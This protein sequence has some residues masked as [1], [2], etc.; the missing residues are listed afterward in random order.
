[1]KVVVIGR[2][3][4]DSRRRIAACFPEVPEMEAV[5]NS[6]TL[7][8]PFREKQ[9]SPSLRPVGWTGKRLGLSGSGAYSVLAS[10]AS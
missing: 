9:K 2:F 10:A 3:P 1:M 8:A 6:D 5:S 4:E 7:S